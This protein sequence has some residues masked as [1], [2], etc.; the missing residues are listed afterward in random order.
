MRSCA[1]HS[2]HVP[3]AHVQ[4]ITFARS[5]VCATIAA[6]ITL[7]PMRAESVK[8]NAQMSTQKQQVV[9]LLKAIE[10]GEPAPVAVINPTKYIQHNLGVGGRPGRLR[11]VACS[12]CP[13]ARPE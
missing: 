7:S 6:V 8:E 2:L 5:M 12:S 13:R 1:S 3:S 4:A 10:T 11:R 9:D